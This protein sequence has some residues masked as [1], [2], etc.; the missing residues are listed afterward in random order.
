MSAFIESIQARAAR[1]PRRIAFSE[2][3]DERVVRAIHALEARHLVQP[4]PVTDPASQTQFEQYAETYFTLRKGRGTTYEAARNIMKDPL[5][6]AAMMVR[7][8]DADGS[9]AGAVRTTA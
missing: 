6:F 8:G 2:M 9:V 4:I 3:D 5:Y 1:A 7:H